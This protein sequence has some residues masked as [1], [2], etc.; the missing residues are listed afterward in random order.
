MPKRV[1]INCHRGQCCPRR[2]LCS[3]SRLSLLP[4]LLTLTAIK[5]SFGAAAGACT[6]GGNAMFSC[7]W[8]WAERV[9]H[10]CD[11]FLAARIQR[12]DPSQP[13]SP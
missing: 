12:P 1:W 5:E 4:A 7:P 11:R 6:N 10:S 3:V 2:Q 9:R 13:S 8:T